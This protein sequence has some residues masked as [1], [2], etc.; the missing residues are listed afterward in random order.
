MNTTDS[1]SILQKISAPAARKFLTDNG[2]S[3]LLDV[4]TPEEYEEGHLPGAR[5]IPDYEL[6]EQAAANLPVKE[7]PLIVY[8]MSGGRSAAA[9][10][11]LSQHGYTQ[12]YD[13][14]SI[15][16]WTAGER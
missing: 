9:A 6:P 13:L 2:N 11:W 10:R 4:R 5:L 16:N 14:G 7:A 8:C 12:I 1:V 15:F 3:I